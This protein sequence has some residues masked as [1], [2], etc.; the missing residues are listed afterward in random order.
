MLEVEHPGLY[1]R[2]MMSDFVV[3]DHP[4]SFNSVAPDM[5]LEQS[6]QRASKSQGGIVGQ[7]RNSA[8]AVE[9]ELIF[10]EILLIQNNFRELTNERV[11]NHRE[12]SMHHELRGNKSVIY[13]NNMLKLLDFVRERAN[14]FIITVPG[15]Q[16]HNLVTM[17]LVT[18]EIKSRLLTVFENGE[19][20]Y[21]QYRQERFILK[22]KKLAVTIPRRNLPRFD[23]ITET[24]SSASRITTLKV[25]A[26]AQ[27]DL[28]IARDRGISLDEIFTYD[29]LLIS[30]L[31]NG[32]FTSATSDM[33]VNQEQVPAVLYS[34]ATDLVEIPELMSWQEEADERIAPHAIW[35]V[36][37]RCQRL[38]VV[39]NGT[40]SVVRLLHSTHCL[41][42]N[43]LK[44]LWIEFGTGKRRQLLPLHQM[45]ER[46][47][48]PL[49]RVLVKAHIL[50]GDDITSRIGTKVAAMQCNPL[51]Y[52]G[53]FGERAELQTD[54][55]AKAEEYLVQVWDGARSKPKAKTFDQLRLDV[56]VNAFTPIAMSNA[57]HI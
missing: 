50:T 26:A 37:Q 7:T 14:P 16:H 6:I 28:E 47:G 53:D 42:R 35:A 8:V 40:D 9:W 15:I 39:S 32:D 31:F 34:P 51:D 12:T 20:F 24:K 11:M 44:E 33:V 27:R 29:F 1:R 48:E 21:H 25:L 22:T 41:Q 54:D 10:H 2:F 49:C 23:T 38:V 5:K 17:Q 30:P 18:D 43:G 4:G 36:Q 57:N 13:N 52:L 19:H 55:I 46:M 3:R 56:Q 45:A